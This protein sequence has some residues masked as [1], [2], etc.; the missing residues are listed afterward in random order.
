MALSALLPSAFLGNR[1]Y[2]MSG[3]AAGCKKPKAPTPSVHS[4]FARALPGAGLVTGGSC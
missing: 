2:I 4:A 3:V 1:T